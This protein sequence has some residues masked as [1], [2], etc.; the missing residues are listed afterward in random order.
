MTVENTS[1]KAQFYGNGSTGPFQFSFPFFKNSWIV[2]TRTDPVLGVTTLLEGVDY[3]L[4]GVGDP[5]GGAL[6]MTNALVVG[7]S[8]LVQRILPLLQDTRLPTGG[9]FFAETHELAFDMLT[10]MVQQVNDRVG[11]VSVNGGNGSNAPTTVNA[12]A[13]A[14]PV[15]VDI[16]GLTDV[17][18]SKDDATGNVVTVS[19]SSGKT[20]ERQSQYRDG[21]S[22][23]D[24]TVHLVLF[25]GN[26]KRV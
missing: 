3:N 26:W 22:G 6:T 14:G 16:K 7:Q 20:I 10:M 24:E 9:P 21:L 5:N 8:L 13:Q 23:Q 15:T 25:G 19:D 2:V 1:S 11:V 18:V 17:V 12:N 4:T